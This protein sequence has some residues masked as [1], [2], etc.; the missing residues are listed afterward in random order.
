MANGFKHSEE[1]KNKERKKV[2][3]LS[4]NGE[5]INE[6]NSVTDVSNYFSVDISVI[7]KRLDKDKEYKGFIFKTK[8]ENNG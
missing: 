7:S 4:I 3:Q 5:L 2:L 8:I 6:F 1:T